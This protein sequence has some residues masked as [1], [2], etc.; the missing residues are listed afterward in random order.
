MIGN[1]S[2][3]P[4]DPFRI[5][6]DAYGNP[7]HY[8]VLAGVAVSG[9]VALRNRLLQFSSSRKA[10]SLQIWH[11]GAQ[12]IANV[13]QTMDKSFREMGTH[14]EALIMANRDCMAKARASVAATLGTNPDGTP[15][16]ESVLVTSARVCSEVLQF[17][18]DGHEV[19]VQIRED[20]DELERLSR[21]ILRIETDIQDQMRPAEVV[22]VLLRIECARLDE[23]ARAPLEALSI[24]IARTC[25]KMAA[26]MEEEFALVEQT[27]ERVM[28]MIEHV[29]M[30]ENRQLFARQR[31]EELTA[32][33]QL[34]QADAQ[35]MADQN[36]M[37][38]AI[39]RDLDRAVSGVMQ[40]MQFQ[41]IVGQRWDHIQQ[42]IDTIARTPAWNDEAAFQCLLQHAQLVEAN[43]EM[44]EALGRIDESFKSVRAASTRLADELQSTMGDA[45][46]KEV[47]VRMHAVL[48]EALDMIRSNAD[49]M[50]SADAMIAPL[51]DV[52][53]KMG[54]HLGNVSHEMRIIA[55]NAQ[56]QAA[57]FGSGTGL[58]VLAEGLR[59]IADQVGNS[60]LMLDADSRMI[61]QLA[62][63]LRGCFERLLAEAEALRRS[64]DERIP[65][66]IDRLL[67]EEN[68]GLLHLKGS[69]DAVH[70]IER[71]RQS[72][73]NSLSSTLVPLERLQAF[74][75]RCDQFVER[76]SR[77]NLAVT[78]QIREHLVSSES[79]RYTMEAEKAVLHN[80]ANDQVGSKRQD[81]THSSSGD[82]EL[83]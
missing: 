41:D 45:R 22:Q 80:L 7:V 46:R 75:D 74:A 6:V 28:G 56:I 33:M 62:V 17:G 53:G 14:L 12:Q 79:S 15:S 43:T 60:G 42:G 4:I 29:R 11:E 57:R 8:D 69:I 16:S 72:M 36:E 65:D 73:E 58:E 1:D 55:L 31:R 44:A 40:A 83:F 63:D 20:L 37:L 9:L 10:P 23:V 48:H 54:N 76:H 51:V 34:L 81:T 2:S 35:V 66:T 3:S 78:A 24:E 13:R 64:S 68:T 71:I 70:Q 21:R 49:E 32:D 27:N 67:A 19:S 77:S 61:E 39:S 25:Q 5:A 59:H 30:L 52:A 26:T 82:I 38:T 18:E 50:R 47:H